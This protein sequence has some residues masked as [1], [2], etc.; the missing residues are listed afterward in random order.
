[1]KNH[2]ED[3]PG[4]LLLESLPLWSG[5]KDFS[6]ETP[7]LLMAALGNP[8]DR[9]SSIHV[10]GTNGKGTVTALLA[11]ILRASGATVGHYSSPHLGHVTERCLINGRPVPALEL[12][13]AIMEVE[14][15]RIRAGLTLTYFELITA[16]SFLIF[17]NRKLDWIVIEVGLGGRLDATNVISSPKLCVITNVE[18]EHTDVLGETRE[19]IARE[20]SGIFKVGVPVVVGEVDSGV[21]EVL[22]RRAAEMNVEAYFL[23]EQFSIQFPDQTLVK[24]SGHSSN[25]PEVCSKFG[26][27]PLQLAA[28]P[29]PAPYLL[30]NAALAVFSAELLGIPERAIEDGLKRGRWPGRLEYITSSLSCDSLILLDVAHNPNGIS[31][32]TRYLKS[33]FLVQKELKQ[34][35]FLV[36]IL[37]RKDWRQ[38]LSILIQFREEA[39]AVGCEVRFIFTDSGHPGCVNTGELT[40]HIYSSYLLPAVD[41]ADAEEA[42]LWAIQ[43]LTA[44]SL[45]VITGSLFLVGRL[46]SSIVKEKFVTIADE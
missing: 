3:L 46:R 18:L 2:T 25:Q 4:L 13:D 19:E 31:A 26:N 1:M 38:M 44:E 17:S 28:F 14:R 16:A 43:H 21:N 23:G 41:I 36:S 9:V 8:Q 35:W 10:T 7:K 27:F 40:K 32:L 42:L 33:E 39:E 12:S 6:F 29:R 24:V 22:R 45:L 15:E 37:E 34:I 5:T 11:A 20:K 30:H